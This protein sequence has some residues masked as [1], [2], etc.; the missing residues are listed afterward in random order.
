[1]TRVSMIVPTR[2]SEESLSA[3]LGSLRAQRHDDLEI[4]V[5]DN[6]STDK[7]VDIA[8]RLADVVENSGPERSAQRNRGA[9]LSTGSVLVFIDSDM[10]VDDGVAAEAAEHCGPGRADLA[11][12]PERVTGEGFWGRCRELEKRL[13]LGD[14]RVE[15]ARVFRRDVFEQLGGYD[16]SLTGPEDWDL[17]DRARRLGLRESRLAAGVLHIDGSP[18]LRRLFAKKRYYG[19]SIPRYLR[20][21]GATG[22]TRLTR[23]GLLRHPAALVRQPLLA[24]GLFAL[25]GWEACGLLVGMLEGVFNSSLHAH[26]KKHEDNCQGRR[27]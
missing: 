14:A 9:S 7:T 15:A 25:K 3:C 5:V 4:V 20:N 2:N 12:I 18:D 17:P 19:R 23:I 6:A 16:L 21:Q 1:M 11:I 26:A 10:I 8:R 22:A 13:Y 24:S 27:R